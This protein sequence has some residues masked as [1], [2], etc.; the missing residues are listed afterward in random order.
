MGEIMGTCELCG[1]ETD[2]L[3][4]VK[5]DST[6]MSAC[7]ACAKYGKIISSPKSNFSSGFA[8]KQSSFVDEVEE[9]IVPDYSRLVR[10]CRVKKGLTP[11]QFAQK[12]NEK[13]SLLRKVESGSFKPSIPLAKKLQ[14]F[15]HVKLVGSR[16]VAKTHEAFES[17]LADK[18]SSDSES[19]SL[20]FGDIL[21]KAMGKK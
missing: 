16:S 19:S 20:T 2:R 21:K 17:S 13:E 5:I 10:D 18:S 15:C 8:G 14:S 4:K 3:V 11:E 9:F 7:S 1:K 6:T 12:L